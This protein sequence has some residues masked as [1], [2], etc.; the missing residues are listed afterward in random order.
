MSTGLSLAN[1]PTNVAVTAN[2]STMTQPQAGVG[3]TATLNLATSSGTMGVV[4]IAGSPGTNGQVVGTTGAAAKWITPVVTIASGTAAW[5]APTV[6]SASCGLATV[7]TVSGSITSIDPSGASGHSC[8]QLTEVSAVAID[9]VAELP[10][11]APTQYL[12]LAVVGT[13][14]MVYVNCTQVGQPSLIPPTA[15]AR[16]SSMA[17]VSMLIPAPMASLTS[18]KETWHRWPARR[19]CCRFQSCRRQT[20][21]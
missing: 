2:N 11:A 21:V 19:L 10:A 16:R 5:S 7:T 20:L 3:N 18:R 15:V 9:T 13:S 17:A 1:I 12:T 4:E 14:I 8:N 6:P